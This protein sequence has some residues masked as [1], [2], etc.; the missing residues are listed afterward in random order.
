MITQINSKRNE[1]GDKSMTFKSYVIK[2]VQLKV[3]KILE[4]ELILV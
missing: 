1:Y 4:V 2:N 3:L